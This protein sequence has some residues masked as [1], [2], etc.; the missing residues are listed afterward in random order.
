MNRVCR[1]A[2]TA[3][4]L[5]CI[6]AFAQPP[7]PEPANLRGDS[8]QTRKRLSEAKQKL[9]AGNAADAVDALQ[10]VLDDAGDDLVTEDG[11]QY[12]AARWRAHQLLSLLPADTL[13]GYQDRTDEPA[14]K[15]L[16]A[17]KRDRD[18][19]PLW[20]LLDRYFVS[21]PADEG[22]LLLGDLLF[23]RGEFRA[24]DRVWRRLLPDAGADA[25]YP[26][27]RVYP[28]AVRARLILGAIFLGELE[29]AKTDF[30]AYELKY[31]G[32]KGWLAGKNAVYTDVLKEYLANPPVVP[33][34]S[35]PANAWP[36]FGGGPD[37]AA[38][39]GAP[40]PRHWPMGKPTWQQN[41]PQLFRHEQ[42]PRSA[43]ARPPFGHPVIAGGRVF[44]TDGVGVYGF[45]LLTGDPVALPRLSAA[46]PPVPGKDKPAPPDASPSMTASG[47]RLYVRVG[48]PLQKAPDIT[49][50]GKPDETAIVCL[51]PGEGGRGYRELWTVRPPGEGKGQ[52][53]WEGAPLVA[54]RRMWAAYARFEGGRMIQGI[55]CFDPA[56]ATSAPPRVAWSADVCDSPLPTSGDPRVRQ[57][58][59][60][61]AGRNVVFCSNAGAVV[62]LD[63]VSGRRA[64]GFRYPRSR[65]ADANRSPD[66]AP[67]V[68]AA[69]RVFVAPADADRV[70]ALDPETGQLLWES[71]PTEG[72]QIVGV[73]AG[74]VV[75]SVTGP[76]RG[77]RGLSVVTGSQLQPDGWVLHEGGG[78]LGYG[79]GFVTEEAV[80][81]P[82]RAGLFFVDPATGRLLGR[83]LFN[84]LG[85]PQSR[86]F[87][88]MA[89]ADGVLTVVAYESGPGG[90][91]GQV[92]GYVSEGKRFGH[93]REDADPVRER[94]GALTRDAEQSLADGKPDAARKLI[95]EA[96]AAEFPTELRAWAAARL[97]LL[98]GKTDAEEKLPADLRAA[99]TPE[100][101]AEWV[102]PPNG[103]PATLDTLVAQH[104]GRKPP[105]TS[106]SPPAA[107]DERPTAPRLSD[108]ADLD[109]VLRLPPG[110]A[111]LRWLPGMAASPT[112]VFVVTADEI[113]TVP[114]G[115]GEPS[116]YAAGHAFTHAADLNE[117]KEFVAAGPL[118]IAVYSAAR[119]PLWVFRVPATDPLPARPGEFRVSSDDS[120][121]VPELSSFRLSGSW[122]VARLGERHLIALDLKGR[123]LAWV[124]GANGE[125]GFRPF[126]LPD[127]AR[128]GAEFFA[129]GRIVVAQ[130]SDGR[131]LFARVESGKL[132]DIP[133]FDHPT[134]RADWSAPPA[135]VEPNR[136]AVSDGPG[137]VRMLNLATGRVKWTHQEDGDA[138]LTGDPPQVR[139]WG[140]NILIAVRRNHGVELDRLGMGE[141]RSEWESGPAFLDADRVNLLNADAD[142]ERV[143]VPAGNSLAALAL[144]DGKPAWE[145]ELP[146]TRGS[147]GWVIRAGRKCVIAYPEA[148]VPREP[149]ATVFDR[150]L[151]SFRGD[152]QAWRLPALAGRLY[153]AWVTR[154]VPVLLFD[155]ETG[156]QLARFDVPAAG[157]AVT[158]WLARDL[159]VVATGDRVVWL[160]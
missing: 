16:A 52:V 66:P 141:G 154:S 75:V 14:R 96:T 116:R 5:A 85:G 114:L 93:L 104:V 118:A 1:V 50:A 43:P 139:A 147:G 8:A 125:T 94:F 10:R 79:R 101:R 134:A 72:A 159:A 71:G 24:A 140:P 62:A 129:A 126:A 4:L 61:L 120:P 54:S 30:A 122:L 160:R 46:T 117:G 82:T 123:R 33:V 7:A 150:V 45:D 98:A 13:K 19:A 91:T 80:V 53:I 89:Y 56:D 81:W 78:L 36:T 68:F 21:R 149:V 26:D 47:D 110:S 74:R 92:W 84:H 18:Q 151:R 37:R 69:G 158:A 49:K 35:A 9:D 17:A 70:Y 41:L 138:S 28:G 100:L 155:P 102:L 131:R 137:L 132:L 44:V 63:A 38:H 112:R 27:S 130:T 95:L 105:A 29:R 55:E 103:I 25:T 136:L 99:L 83:P 153:D 76:V 106:V 107:S 22:L 34:A 48:S 64:W 31:H 128:F 60:T 156:K 152:P 145:A 97:L 88:N 65:K 6:P 127:A 148:A 23:E 109:R 2:A 15:L 39:V 133:G 157:P 90:A 113:I 111:P 32:A 59:L 146:D 86:L 124:L 142:A 3:T 11:K 87:G 115:E 144:K 20:N 57:E 108:D 135:E 143:Y 51:G 42:A 77:L 58:L 121:P 119:A 40:L 12:R 73:A 67:A